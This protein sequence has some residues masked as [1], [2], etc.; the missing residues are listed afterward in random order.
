MGINLQEQTP[1]LLK[2]YGWDLRHAQEDTILPLE[3][4]EK[5][6]QQIIKS[7]VNGF[8]WEGAYPYIS[9]SNLL[10]VKNKIMKEDED[11]VLFVV[12]PPGLGKT[13]F[14]LGCARFVD[15]TFT[16][17]RT[18]FTMKH[19]KE[20]L[21]KVSRVY[22]KVAKGRE[23]GENIEN[24]YAGKCLIL[25]EGVYLLFSGD[26]QSKNGKLAQKLFSII[27]ALNLIIIVN[28]TNLRK[29]NKGVRED[30][31]L[32]L[33]RIPTKGIVQFYSK[34]KINQINFK[35]NSLKYP[36]AN[37]YEKTGWIANC[38]FWLSY[39]VMKA[40]FLVGATEKDQ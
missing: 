26:T 28:V 8:V 11:S 35:E 17:E 25:D 33:F 23:N 37:F 13:T 6:N 2:K 14:S 1:L 12:A 5:V 15:P 34:K 21:N 36:K 24:P 27:R 38:P 3:E 30:R 22:R 19:L 7:F 10:G 4:F 29:I 32:A 31:V 39:G 40:Q 18:I 9:F 16:N 20:F